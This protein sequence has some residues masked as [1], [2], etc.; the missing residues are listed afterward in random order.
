MLIVLVSTSVRFRGVLIVLVLTSVRVRG[1]MIVL[2][3][4]SVRAIG[5][6][7]KK[8]LVAIVY[9]TCELS[10][11]FFLFRPW[12]FDAI[13]PTFFRRSFGNLAKK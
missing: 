6:G 13:S 10:S 2:V 4:T 11:F 1:V 7:R 5:G 9:A 12:S 3:L 8:F